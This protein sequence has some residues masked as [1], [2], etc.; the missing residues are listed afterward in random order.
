MAITHQVAIH[1]CYN[2]QRA[3]DA[4]AAKAGARRQKV[5]T[6]AAKVRGKQEAREAKI[7]AKEA[8]REK[9]IADRRDK[10]SDKLGE[11]KL[12]AN[13][14]CVPSK[15]AY[16]EAPAADGMISGFFTVIKPV[17]APNNG[18]WYVMIAP[19]KNHIVDKSTG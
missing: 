7:A 18:G 6:K 9:H 17:D 2:I 14:K 11:R 16:T 4:K 3:K 10:V 19:P 5:E 13:D 8:A 1:G 15:F 12:D